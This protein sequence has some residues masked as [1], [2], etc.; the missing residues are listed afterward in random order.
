[1]KS[2]LASSPHSRSLGSLYLSNVMSAD[3]LTIYLEAIENQN[4]SV[5]N[6]EEHISA[7]RNAPSFQLGKLESLIRANESLSIQPLATCQAV[8]MLCTKKEC[9][10]LLHAATAEELKGG[11]VGALAVTEN[12]EK[13]LSCTR[14][15][16]LPTH[17]LQQASPIRL[18]ASRCAEK[19]LLKL[20][21]TPGCCCSDCDW[22]LWRGWGWRGG[23]GWGEPRRP[24]MQITIFGFVL[25]AVISLLLVLAL[26]YSMFTIKCEGS[27]PT[28]RQRRR[29]DVRLVAVALAH[30]QCRTGGACLYQGPL[31]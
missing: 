9:F 2:C 3:R 22:G 7:S 11:D 18:N 24:H 26:R 25:L 23:W 15:L 5:I 28:N 10:Q 12:A 16:Q 4:L 6:H 17:A 21:S 30:V 14:L 19:G 20:V 29:K 1:M 27:S 13:L 31:Q 8:G